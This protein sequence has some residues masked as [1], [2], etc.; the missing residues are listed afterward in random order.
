MDIFLILIYQHK[1]KS[2]HNKIYK[3]HTYRYVFYS[4]LFSSNKKHIALGI[5]FII[6]FFIEMYI[7]SKL[8]YFIILAITIFYIFHLIWINLNDMSI[9]IWHVLSESIW[10]YCRLFF[11]LDHMND[12]HWWYVCIYLCSADCLHYL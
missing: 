9:E 12:L 4:L 7:C 10:N 11:T 1:T 5:K 6:Y 2:F 8:S 3:Q